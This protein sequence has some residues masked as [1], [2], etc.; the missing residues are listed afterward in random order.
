M[1]KIGIIGCGW[2]GS[3]IAEKLSGQFEIYVT[4]TSE[5]KLEQFQKKGF[6]PMIADFNDAQSIEFLSPWKAIADLDTVIITVPFSTKKDNED[7]VLKRAANLVSF[8]HG[9]QGQIFLMSSTGVYPDFE[10]D[11]S[12]DDLSSDHAA[13]E[14][15]IKNAFPKTN[16]LRLAGLMGDDRVLSK[17]TI[18][19]LDVRVNHIHYA[20]ICSVIEK[21]MERQ[22]HSKLYNLAAPMHPQKGEVISAQ[23]NIP[24]FSKME[25]GGRTIS[26]E[27]LISELDFDFKFPDPRYFHI[28]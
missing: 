11:F 4:T 3:R 18:S 7:E 19:N 15:V 8:M 24:Y 23:K 5:H 20:D 17:Y 27:K 22:L 13:G 10:K 25:Y 12:E 26:S 9:F 6:H 2:L 1:K 14:R 28:D 16:I 21:M